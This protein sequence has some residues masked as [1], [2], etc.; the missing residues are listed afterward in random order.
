MVHSPPNVFN[1]PPILCMML[2]SKNATVSNFLTHHHHHINASYVT[3]HVVHV[4]EYSP[5]IVSLA[6]VHSTDNMVGVYV[7][8]SAM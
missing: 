8:L 6:R 4:M 5:Q 1:V 2:F 3:Q 7:S